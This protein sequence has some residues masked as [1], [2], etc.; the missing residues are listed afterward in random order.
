M[1]LDTA[2]VDALTTEEK[3]CLQKEGCCF[4]C[5]KMGH[6]SKNCQQRKENTP[7]TSCRN[8]GTTACV[9]EVKEKEHDERMIEE[10]KGMS[11]KKRNVLLNKL[12]LQGF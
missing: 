10:I 3:M 9:T 12:A 8:Q 7:V 5:K 6:I 11:S 2:Q 1:D 4:H